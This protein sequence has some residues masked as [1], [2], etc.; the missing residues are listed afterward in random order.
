MTLAQLRERFNLA[1][2]IRDR[3][4]DANEAVV[5]IRRLKGEVDDRLDQTDDRP[6]EEQ[7]VVVKTRLSDVEGEI[8]QVRNESSQD[9]LNFP[10]KLNNKIAALMNG[11]EGGETDP[12]DAQEQVF[13]Y[14][15]EA[16]QVELIRLNTIIQQDL[17]R[18]N[19]LLREA[20][21]DEIAVEELIG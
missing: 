9:P 10:I 12:T 3:V 21:M 7:G 20:G 19:E 13:D 4:S 17:R 11:V 15:S 16:L 14:L 18:L 6:I 5:E 1:M 2:Q 8:Y